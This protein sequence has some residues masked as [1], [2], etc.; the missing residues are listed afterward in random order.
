[1]V[2][3]AIEDCGRLGAHAQAFLRTLVER[4]VRQG[5][6]SRAPLRDPSRSVLRSD[7]V[8]M[9]SLWAQRWHRHISSWLHLSLSRQF[10][11]LFRP[12]QASEDIFS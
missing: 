5:R 6:R 7:G 2:P 3:F 11:R 1:M 8:T 4:V 12:Q 9:V 10:L